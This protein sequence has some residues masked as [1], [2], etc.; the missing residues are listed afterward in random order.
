MQ[1]TSMS[2]TIEN[3]KS[4]ELV[5]NDT[6]LTWH[7][8]SIVLFIFLWTYYT[9]WGEMKKKVQFVM[10]YRNAKEL[11]K[12]KSIIN[13]LIPNLVRS[14]LTDGKKNFAES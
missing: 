11:Q 8:L 4:E 2:K 1:K 5:S 7:V 3:F 13:I 10:Q 9:Y 14:R 6:E 12:L